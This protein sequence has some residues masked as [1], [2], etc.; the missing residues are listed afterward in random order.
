[1]TKTKVGLSYIDLV[2]NDRSRQRYEGNRW[3]PE[4]GILSD[5][6]RDCFEIGSDFE[7]GSRINAATHDIIMLKPCVEKTWRPKSRMTFDTGFDCKYADNNK[8]YDAIVQ[9]HKR[10][11]RVAVFL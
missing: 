7:S 4:V 3:F 8:R 10:L 11:T 2:Y 6:H 1:M 9:Q 5:N